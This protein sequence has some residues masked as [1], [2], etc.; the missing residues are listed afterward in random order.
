MSS[1]EF[2]VKCHNCNGEVS[3]WYQNI[4]YTLTAERSVQGAQTIYLS[5]GC[6]IDFP[7]WQVDVR[8]GLVRILD[9]T[10]N[11]FIEFEDDE[12]LLEEED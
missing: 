9:F 4:H 11:L 10:G 8:T 5:C 7:D 6:S 12:M 1:D 2:S 3:G